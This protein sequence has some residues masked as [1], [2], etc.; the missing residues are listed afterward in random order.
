MVDGC[1][2][3]EGLLLLLVT[4]QYQSLAPKGIVVIILSPNAKIVRRRYAFL[5]DTLFAVSKTIDSDT[6]SCAYVL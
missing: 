1:D 3:A 4:F 5:V 6:K 2:N